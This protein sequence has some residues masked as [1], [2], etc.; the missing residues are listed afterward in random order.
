MGFLPRRQTAPRVV[1][2]RL[3]ESA[4]EPL[5]A[6][7]AGGPDQAQG[8]DAPRGSLGCPE[9]A[10]GSAGLYVPSSSPIPQQLR[11]AGNKQKTP[12]TFSYFSFK[13]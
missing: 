12:I 3:R 6:T 1:Q 13:T 4:S 11:C 7:L 2:K 5:A 9:R 8:A 10:P